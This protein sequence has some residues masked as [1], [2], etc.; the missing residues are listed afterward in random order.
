MIDEFSNELYETSELQSSFNLLTGTFIIVDKS[1]EGLCY[2]VSQPR[3]YS[4]N[5]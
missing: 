5:E 4:Q 3:V 2:S 1:S